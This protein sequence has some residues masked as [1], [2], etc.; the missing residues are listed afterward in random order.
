MKNKNYRE[1]NISPQPAEPHHHVTSFYSAKKS[2][3]DCEWKNQQHDG[4][5][6]DESVDAVYEFEN[7]QLN[8]EIWKCDKCGNLML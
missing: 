3:D 5:E 8:V 6:S 4:Y 7:F 2:G 1:P